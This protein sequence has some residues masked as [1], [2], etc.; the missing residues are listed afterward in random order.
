MAERVSP[1]SQDTSADENAAEDLKVLFPE[2]TIPIG[3]KSI[4][5]EEYPFM[6]WLELKPICEP[7]IEDFA[8]FIDRKEDILNDEILEC[9]E[10]N[11]QIMQ[12]LYCES[13]HQDVKFLRTLKDAE[14]EVLMFSWWSVNKHFFIKSAKR[15][16]R[17]NLKHATDGQTSSSV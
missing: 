1:T 5:V 7:L 10:N 14:M 15:R 4:T 8:E 9:F 13:I 16:L 3:G 11:F 12:Q 17:T 2:I 6:K